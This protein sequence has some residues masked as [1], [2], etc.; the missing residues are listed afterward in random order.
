MF[1]FVRRFSGVSILVD[2]QAGFT[3]EFLM[4]YVTFERFF[5]SVYLHMASANNNELY[6][7]RLT[8]ADLLINQM[9]KRTNYYIITIVICAIFM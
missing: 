4:A 1:A 7:K 6:T 3:Y 9:K 8:Y 2:F 5:S